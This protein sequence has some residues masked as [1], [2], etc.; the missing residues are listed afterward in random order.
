MFATQS[1]EQWLQI[2]EPKERR[3]DLAVSV[4]VA[5]TSHNVQPHDL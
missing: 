1:F 3:D 5:D 2:A 4:A